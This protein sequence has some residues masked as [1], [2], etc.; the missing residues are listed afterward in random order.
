M[1]WRD[2]RGVVIVLCA[3]ILLGVLAAIVLTR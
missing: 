3:T 2:L 1:G